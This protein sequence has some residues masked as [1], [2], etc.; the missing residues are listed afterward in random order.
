MNVER[1][2]WPTKKLAYTFLL[3]CLWAFSSVPVAAMRVP[4][5][6]SVSLATDTPLPD[7][8]Y[9][10]NPIADAS[11]YSG[12]PNN[13]FGTA[14]TLETDNSPVKNFLIKFNI[15]GIGVRQVVKATL[16]LYDIDPSPKGGD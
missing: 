3:L 5:I 2:H 11:L 4:N 14:A 15:T 8:I 1:K 16:R 7:S 10:F 9:T 6:N 13:N 12:S